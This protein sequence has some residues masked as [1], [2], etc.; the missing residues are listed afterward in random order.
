MHIKTVPYFFDF[1]KAY[2]FKFH[3]NFSCKNAKLI[4]LFVRKFL[5]GGKKKKKKETS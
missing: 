3:F 4:L 2:I 5:V 1:N